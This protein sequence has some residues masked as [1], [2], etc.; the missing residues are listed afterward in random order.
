[1]SDKPLQPIA[2]QI[3]QLNT[4]AIRDM[5]AIAKEL[6]I[7]DLLLEHQREAASMGVAGDL[8][9]LVEEALIRLGVTN[10]ELSR[11]L[12]PEPKA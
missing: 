2:A 7:V 6:G 5:R 12:E 3:R 9:E 10:T 8:Y 1:M 11:N 4:P